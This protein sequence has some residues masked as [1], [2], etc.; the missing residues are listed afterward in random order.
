MSDGLSEILDRFMRLP[1]PEV[2]Q[3]AVPAM[4]EAAAR[5]ANIDEKV[6]RPK[7]DELIVICRRIDAALGAGEPLSRRDLRRAPW[8]LWA[9]DM[10]LAE[11]PGRIQ[12]LLD[13]LVAAGRAKLFK[14]LAFAWGHA[15]ALERAGIA[16]VG[17]FLWAHSHLLGPKWVA[18]L[19]RWPLFDP[20]KGPRALAET[21]IDLGK[22]P[23]T[24]LEDEGLGDF[25]KCLGYVFSA[26][27]L[28]LGLLERGALRDPEKRLAILNSWIFDANHK[29]RHASLSAPAVRAAIDPFG[30]TMPEK[31]IRD[32]YIAFALSLLGDP[33]SQP[34]KWVNCRR[35]QD[36][37]RRWLTEQTLRQFFDVVDRVA[38]EGHWKY[39]RA[40]WNALY[41]KDLIDEAWVI[42]EYHGQQ[43]ARRMFGKDL[44]FGTIT[45]AGT[46]AGH[47]IL[48]LR[49]GTLTVAEW[50]HSSPCSIWDESS[51][52][53]GPQLYKRQ[54]TASELKKTFVGS[55]S[56]ENAA[57]QGVFWHRNSD[58]YA[59][60]HHIATYLKKR[61]GI[62][63]PEHEY[64]V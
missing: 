10:P 5:L 50:S 28:G 21:A 38:S 42:F 2:R 27:A 58:V 63:I 37:L 1:F 41:A 15:F 52:E 36:I 57:K 40:F 48:L 59:W 9:P 31:G 4:A 12:M 23:E 34:A 30:D 18:A 54:Y 25:A 7:P 24:L 26:Y 46:Q 55:S 43:E 3:R 62:S 33:R 22:S 14:T 13:Q 20:Q 6:E 56:G 51:Q 60:Q 17:Q 53:R 32:R 35:S 29:L 49:I 64:R 47:S 39:R 19:K 61:R 44:E 11:I 16:P 8:C 45:S